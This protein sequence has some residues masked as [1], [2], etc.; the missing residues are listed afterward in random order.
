MGSIGEDSG[1]E[2]HH[3]AAGRLAPAVGVSQVHNGLHLLV[4]QLP[5]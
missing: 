2:G 3:G 5:I 1:G 4:V